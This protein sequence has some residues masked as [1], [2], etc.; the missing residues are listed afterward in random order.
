MYILFTTFQGIH[1]YLLVSK[2]T[3]VY[4]IEHITSNLKIV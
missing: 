4:F 1:Y 3:T 2:L